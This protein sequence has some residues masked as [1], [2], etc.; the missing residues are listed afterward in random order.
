MAKKKA[1]EMLLVGS[2]TKEALQ[3][4]HTI[5]WRKLIRPAQQAFFCLN[6]KFHKPIKQSHATYE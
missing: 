2:K 3:S 4:D 1:K 5:S 6:V